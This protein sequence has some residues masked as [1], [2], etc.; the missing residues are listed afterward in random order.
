VRFLC[1]I[2]ALSYVVSPV[3]MASGAASVTISISPTTATVGPAGQQQFTATVNRGGVSWSVDGIKGGTA[4]SGTISTTGLYVAPQTT[5]NHIIKATSTADGTKSAAATVQVSVPTAAT[6]A[7]NFGGR[8]GA[9]KPIPAGMIG[10]QLGALN[11]AA[12]F[13]LLQQ[14]NYGELRIDAKLH[15]VFANGTTPDWTQ[16]DPA[17][18]LVQSYGL[19][20]LIMVGYTP[21]WL[22]ISPNPCPSG[23]SQYHSAPADVNQ[24]GQ[25]VAALVA[26]LDQK[27]PGLVVDYEI[28]NEPDTTSG[29]CVPDGNATTRLNTYVAMYS[30]A[31]SAMHAQAAADRA[32][33]RVG[34][35]VLTTQS[36]VS[37]WIPALVGNSSTAPYVDFVS[38]HH[39]LAGQ[40]DIINGIGWDNTTSPVSYYSREQNSTSGAAAYFSKV[41]ALVKQGLQPNPANT[42]VFLTEYQDN[43]AFLNDCCR[44][45]PTYAPLLNALWV[46]DTLNTVYAG[47]QNVPAKLTYFSAST[48]SGAF[49]LVGTIDASMDCAASGPIAGY[50]Q[51][52]THKLIGGSSYMNLNN[53]GFMAASISGTPMPLVTTAFYTISGNAILLVNP[54]ATDFNNLGVVVQNPGGVSPQGTMYVLNNANQSITSQNIS[55]TLDGG[56][57]STLVNVPAYTVMGIILPTGTTA[58]AIQVTMNPTSASI[59]VGAQQQ[60]AASVTGTNNTGVTWYVDGIPGGSAQVGTISSAGLFTA[61]A[62]GSHSVTAVSMADLARSAS[63]QVSVASSGTISVTVAPTT[64]SISA[65]QTQQFTATVS[66]TNTSVTW[67]VDGTVGGNS[68]AGMISAMGLYTPGLAG[69]HTVTATSAAD[70]LSS[71]SAT[72]SVSLAIAVHPIATSLTLTQPQQFTAQVLGASNTAVTWAVDGV[73]GGNSSVGTITSSGLYTPPTAPGTHSIKAIS[74]ADSTKSAV[75]AAVVTDF[76]GTT[77]YH[78]DNGRTGQNIQERLLSP[79]NVTSSQF[80]KLSSYPVDGYVYAQPLYVANLFIPGVGY[81]NLLY[82]ATA[83]DSLYAFNA[84]SPGITPLWK[85][86]FLNTST[87]VTAIPT[88]DFPSATVANLFGPEIGIT[89][90]PVIDPVKKLIYL[91]AATREGGQH[92]QRLHAIDLATG[93]EPLPPTVIQGSVPGTGSGSTNGILPFDPHQH[94]QRAGL[95]VANGL[96][97]VAFAAHYDLQPY[98]GWVFAYDAGTFVRQAIYCVS[99][100]TSDYGGGIWM[101][102]SAPGIDEAGN[103][104]VSTGNGH[105]NVITGGNSDGDSVLKLSG[106]TLSV[107]DWFA[108]SNQDLLYTKD[109]DLGSGG[110]LLLPDQTN[111]IHT[112]ELLTYGKDPAGTLFLLDRD[113]L[114]HYNATGDTQIAQSVSNQIGDGVIYPRNMPAYWNGKVYTAVEN[115]VIKTF[116]LS[117]GLLSTTPVAK[118]MLK[119]GHPGAT[120]SV[121]ANGASNGIVWV[122]RLVSGSAAVLH[123]FNA[124]NV[125]IELYNSNQAGT[126]DLPAIGTTFAVPT[127][128]NGKVYVAG[129]TAV[130]VFGLIP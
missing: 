7:V 122:I 73:V 4:S 109:Y 69:Q 120:P 29:L 65:A 11:S 34:G 91:V 42:P 46:A 45:S 126:R 14:A 17:I 111:T 37:S 43:W 113:S 8:S 2:L 19:R 81:R 26:H 127:I 61:T 76:A 88:S 93:A 24:W 85:I 96:I 112:H 116:S 82:I 99:P 58:D 27:F 75:A 74:A 47:T 12:G 30:A 90:T 100:D 5:G 104:Y 23:V 92:V 54:A 32:R 108:P 121:S 38:Y 95:A 97:Y 36:L 15:N 129:R 9:T 40:T 25:L 20:P 49:C 63:A 79:S 103:V 72:V 107:L 94:L 33:I 118:G 21:P 59:S 101:S 68:A 3:F 110:T 35:P 10:A 105:T 13:Q 86:S 31:G 80:G 39:Y 78:N 28:W 119:L 106:T 83:H 117:N 66:G 98:H 56:S 124:S 115:D 53:G 44:N 130:T 114:G 84:D 89:G 125:S 64:A 6:V 18:T 71:G 55:F 52:F 51:Y 70:G 67:S 57:L 102:G 22:Q 87:G 62:A 41:S 50:P 1:M 60:F 16:L 77:T 128:A 48:P 123:A